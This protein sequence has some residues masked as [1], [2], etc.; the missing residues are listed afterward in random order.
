MCLYIHTYIYKYTHVIVY[1]K[2]KKIYIYINILY[3]YTEIHNT[4]NPRINYLH[5]FNFFQRYKIQNYISNFSK[6]CVYA[7]FY[8]FPYIKKTS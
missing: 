1:D 2:D 3:I 6:A 4:N 5:I 8:I 7:N